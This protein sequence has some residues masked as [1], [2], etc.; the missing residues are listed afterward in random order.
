MVLIVSFVNVE[1]PFFFF[2]WILMV[3]ELHQR[4]VTCPS[5]PQ[6]LGSLLCEKLH[7]GAR[8]IKQNDAFK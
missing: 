8:K 7:A 5:A 6:C 4:T 1:W 2:K 3:E